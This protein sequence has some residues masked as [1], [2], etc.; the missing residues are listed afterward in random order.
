MGVLAYIGPLVFVTIFAA[1]ESPFARYHANQGLVLLIFSVAYGIIYGILS[2][3]LA[4]VFLYSLSGLAVYGIITTLLGLLSLA[5]LVL[6]IIGIVN[7][8]QG[9]CKPLPIIG[10]INILK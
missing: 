1:K 6:A 2:A 5:F 7:A 9:K 3:L 4:A 10:K 8:V